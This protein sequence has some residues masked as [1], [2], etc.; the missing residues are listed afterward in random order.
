MSVFS[1]PPGNPGGIRLGASRLT[2]LAERVGGDRLDTLFTSAGSAEAALPSRR[3]ADFQGLYEHGAAAMEEAAQVFAD[4]A[5]VLAD[6][7]DALEAAQS[8][9]DAAS[10]E[11]DEARRSWTVARDTGETEMESRA[12]TDMSR[13]RGAAL[14]AQDTFAE[15]A[16]RARAS[17]SGLAATWSP[18]GAATSAV[19]AWGAATA[20]IVPGQVGLSEDQLEAIFTGDT[21]PQQLAEAG[22]KVQKALINGW[23][24][25]QAIAVGRDS[26]AYRR[27]VEAIRQSRGQGG[28]ARAVLKATRRSQGLAGAHRYYKNMRRL[29]TDTTA[30]R[31]AQSRYPRS[32]GTRFR[33]AEIRSGAPRNVAAPPGLRGA[34]GRIGNSR[35]VSGMRAGGRVLAPLGAVTGGYDIYRA[36]R[37]GED[38]TNTDRVVTGLGGA[39]GLAAGGLATYALVAGVALGPVG[40]GIVAVGGAVAAGA[41]LYQNREAVGDAAEKVV[42]AGKQVFEGAKDVGQKVWDGLFG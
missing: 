40:L 28:S 34:M 5:V 1:R 18:D 20:A 29:Q 11:Y 41:W 16:A 14:S 4:V 17:L 23:Y 32:Q 25:W 35:I 33:Y 13:Q 21:S 24:S 8:A 12:R 31:H 37:G 6:Y 38:M 42:D 9:V 10:E 27:V 26:A 36:I 39:G 7:A 3:K 19:D 15:A 2:L 30:L 22:K